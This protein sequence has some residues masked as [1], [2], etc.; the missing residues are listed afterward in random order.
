[1]KQLYYQVAILLFFSIFVVSGPVF[2]EPTELSLSD[3][4][5]LALKNNPTIKIAEAGKEQSA[6]GVEQAKAGKGFKLDYSH[7]EARTNQPY[8]FLPTFAAISPYNAFTNQL[9]LTLPLF[10]GGKLE[11]TLDEAKHGL[12]YSALNLNA[13]EQQLKLETTS[14]YF[15]ALQTRNLQEVAKQSVD[16]FAAHLKN[17]QYQ[18]QEGNVAM[19]DVLQT[20][21]QWAN[22]QDNFIK[23][24]NNYYL[25]IYK[26]NNIIGLPLHSELN[27]K[28]NFEYQPYS[29]TLDDCIKYAL[30]NR[31][32]MI[33]AQEN[34]AIAKDQVKI[35]AS[36]ALP[37]VGIN[38]K[39]EWDGADFPG[40]TYNNWTVAISVNYDVF[41]SGLTKANIK[42]A[43][44]GIVTAKEQARQ[45]KDN[46]ALEVSQAYLTMKEAEE[47]IST[48]KVA[49]EQAE[50]DFN[51]ANE[52]YDAGVGI[53][54][55]V[56]DAELALAQ[57][58]TNYVQALY[59]YNTGKAQ[60]DKAMG[61]P[62]MK[63]DGESESLGH[64]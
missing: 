8:S 57:A 23:A 5:V 22:A 51:L 59:D 61:V 26:L 14:A 33:E 45:L 34:V 58:K 19:A 24:R 36:D 41:D 30:S 9:S 39:K 55:D 52:R 2:A 18:Y 35:A 25:A 62:V 31:P 48:C 27:L 37:T 10:T 53:N 32:E 50:V 1:M 47:R 56:I 40:T 16:D 13:T 17:L 38:G 7:V 28:E 43:E 15:N 3:S 63:A 21:V 20:K 54:L 6:W 42:K 60:L 4:I 29:T 46:I 44:Y 12:N 49:V 64:G 11:N